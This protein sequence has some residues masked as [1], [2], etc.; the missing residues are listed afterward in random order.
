LDARVR[1]RR[2]LPPAHGI[3]PHPGPNPNLHPRPNPHP[4]DPHPND[5][6]PNDRNPN[7]SSPSHPNPSP[8]TSP[9][10]DLP[11]TSV[12]ATAGAWGCIQL[13][14]SGDNRTRRRPPCS[15]CFCGLAPGRA[16]STT[17]FSARSR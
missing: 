11:P 13:P 12:G 9:R 17:S 4:T 6:H 1:D 15:R 8:N 14:Q 5:P 3:C 2:H 10:R 16:L 7:N